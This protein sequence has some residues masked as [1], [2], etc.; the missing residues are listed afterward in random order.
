[1]IWF[2]LHISIFLFYFKYSFQ[3]YHLMH[4]IC[5]VATKNTYVGFTTKLSGSYSSTTNVI[6][7]NEILFNQGNAYN[8]TVFKCPSPGLYFFHVSVLS[9]S[10]SNGVYIYKNS[11]Q[12]TLA[13]SGGDPQNNGASVSAAM[14][15]D[16][17]DQVYL[18]PYSSSLHL[19]GN[20]AFTGIKII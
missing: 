10:S 8:G 17:G 2:F 11:K 18:L 6:K 4:F 16:I 9:S 1:M 5:V 15:L 12:L 14:W 3:I 13:Y 20:S 7:G 19:D